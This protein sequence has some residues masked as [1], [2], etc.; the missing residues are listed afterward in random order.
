MSSDLKIA[1]LGCL[2]EMSDEEL[3]VTGGVVCSPFKKGDPRYD[4]RFI[5]CPNP[6]LRLPPFVVIG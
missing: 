3:R 1:D 5:P 4:P 6:P 2:S